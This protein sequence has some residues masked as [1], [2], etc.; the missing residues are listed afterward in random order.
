MTLLDLKMRLTSD[1]DVHILAQWTSTCGHPPGRIVLARDIVIVRFSE[2]RSNTSMTFVCEKLRDWVENPRTSSPF[3]CEIVKMN[4]LEISYL[5]LVKLVLKNKRDSS[6]CTRELSERFPFLTPTHLADLQSFFAQSFLVLFN[7]KWKKVS[8][9]LPRLKDKF[10]EW[11]AQCKIIDLEGQSS[12]AD[13]PQP[14]ELVIPSKKA[15]RKQKAFDDCGPKAKK[16]KVKEARTLYPATLLEAAAA[17][18]SSKTEIKYTPDAA[19]TLMIEMML[20]KRSYQIMR[21]SAKSLGNDIYPSYHRVLE[22]KK[23]CYPSDIV[24]TERSAMVPLQSLLDHTARRLLE[25]RSSEEIAAMPLELTLATKW[26]CDGSS[27]HSEYQQKFSDETLSDASIF[28]STIVPLEL[29]SSD[30]M[31]VWGN[32]KPS[33]TWYCRPLRFEFTKETNEVIL[34]E[35]ARTRT[36]IEEL[37]PSEVV[38]TGKK[39]RIRHKLILSMIDGKIAQ[40]LSG[41]TAM[42]NCCV[43]GASPKDMNN[44]GAISKREVSM[45]ALKL[46]LSP[47]HA[48]I[49][50]MECFLHISYRLETPTWRVNSS[51]AER[52][53]QRKT[54][55]QKRFYEKLGIKVDMVKKGMGTTNDGN[56]AR[57]FFQ[58]AALTSSITGVDETLLRRFGVI[59]DA[60]NCNAPIKTAEFSVYCRETADLYVKLY[61][62]YYMPNAVHRLLIHGPMIAELAEYPLGALSEEAQEAAN[63]LY[64][65][66][67]LFHARKTGRLATN[68]D[69]FRMFLAASDPLINSLRSVSIETRTIYNSAELSSLLQV[70]SICS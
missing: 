54:E 66:Y 14:V 5:E 3:V 53:K 38:V 62:W 36:E 32:P 45:E 10:G 4:K 52:V 69:V 50:S 67:R 6:A 44:L 31:I 22:A 63:K 2:T 41:Q 37:I 20:S 26:G 43:C 46:G 1:S 9:S 56:L 17:T 15:G 29:T 13:P 55:I 40:I 47:L 58:D 30:G 61:P 57:R 35:V 68:E 8:R 7:R 12:P 34:A 33:S 24:C 18:I 23:A 39:I 11:L 60:I 59:L 48:R 42:T 49:K 28:L 70:K 25:S 21:Q 16:Y 51:N 64:K 65:Q 27:G 19:L